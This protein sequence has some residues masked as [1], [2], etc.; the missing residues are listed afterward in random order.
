MKGYTMS[1]RTRQ[2]KAE[3]SKVIAKVEVNLHDELRNTYPGNY[4][5]KFLEMRYKAKDYERK[6]EKRRSKKQKNI[7]RRLKEY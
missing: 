6:I 4:E 2:N 3:P 1:Q 5:R 7:K